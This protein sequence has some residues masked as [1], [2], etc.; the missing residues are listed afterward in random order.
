MGERKC[1]L[2]SERSQT[3]KV[4]YHM[5]PNIRHSG[6]GKPIETVKRSAF[7][8]QRLSEGRDE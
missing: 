8:C 2:V 7:S 4:T 6:K 5:S 3:E 1:I